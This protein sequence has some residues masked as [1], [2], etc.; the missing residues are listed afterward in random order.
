MH[1]HLHW[2]VALSALALGDHDAAWATYR[3]T[4]APGAAWGPPLNLVTD[5]ASFLMRAALAGE[6]VEA[7]AWRELAALAQ[8]LFPTPGI[9][10]A[11]AHV[12]LALAMCGDHEALARLRGAATGPAAD[13]VAALAEA[14]GAFANND[15]AATL[16]ALAPVL[17]THERLGGSRAQRDLVEQL[18]W[19]AIVRGRLDSAWRPRPTRALPARMPAPP[20]GR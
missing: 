13:V 1:L 5:A 14:F 10:F 20:A 18:A 11:D 4:V 16:R 8:R 2:H 12:A 17:A 3:A 19:V 7:V 15:M 6:P 9:A